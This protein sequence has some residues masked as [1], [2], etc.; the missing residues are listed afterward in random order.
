MQ[1]RKIIDS[2]SKD[3]GNMGFYCL[4]FII[5]FAIAGLFSFIRGSS[6]NLIGEKVVIELRN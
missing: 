3:D 5:L 1:F 2:I 6:Y 4:E